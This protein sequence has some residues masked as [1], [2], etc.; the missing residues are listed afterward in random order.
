MYFTVEPSQ[1]FRASWV[2]AWVPRLF[3]LSTWPCG[4]C[5]A[6]LERTEAGG[7]VCGWAGGVCV[8]LGILVEYRGLLSVVRETE[9]VDC[10][11]V[12]LTLH[13]PKATR[14]RKTPNGTNKAEAGR[15]RHGPVTVTPQIGTCLAH[16]HTQLHTR[17]D[18]YTDRPPRGRG[19]D[20]HIALPRKALQGV[21][22]PSQSV[23]TVASR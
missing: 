5:G 2:H 7:C 20:T 9:C 8:G 16:T 21:A 19:A 13:T 6:A 10:K 14:K 15:Q 4:V 1:F 17:R 22:Q 12:E 3:W 11:G 23:L 18:R